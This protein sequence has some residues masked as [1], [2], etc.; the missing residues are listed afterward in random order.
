[1][2]HPIQ[3]PAMDD[4]II[5]GLSEIEPASAA[6]PALDQPAGEPA[7]TSLEADT[8]GTSGNE[9]DPPLWETATEAVD[10]AP[11][12]VETPAPTTEKI[13]AGHAGPLP[14]MPPAQKKKNGRIMLI[15][16]GCLVALLACCC[17]STL[18]MYFIGGDWLLNQLGYLP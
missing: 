3:I 11:S 2:A 14:A 5:E 10:P 1:L 8:D 9:Y 17:S 18:F 4:A 15:T 6:P 13:G 12:P 16:A 7:P